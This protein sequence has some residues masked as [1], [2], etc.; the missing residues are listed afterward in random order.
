MEANDWRRVLDDVDSL[1]RSG[2]FTPLVNPAYLHHNGRPLVAVWGA[3][4]NDN[5][6]YGLDE[7]DRMVSGLKERG[8][9]VLLGV[10]TY[11]RTL[12][13]DTESDARLHDIISC[14]DVVMPWFVGRYNERS[15]DRHMPSVLAD[16][17]WCRERGVDYAPLAF[18]GFSWKNMKGQDAVTIP[19]NKGKFLKNQLNAYL[20]ANAQMIY[21]AMFDEIDEGTAIFKCARK[22]PISEFGTTFVESDAESD[23]YLKIV[24]DAAKKLKLSINQKKLNE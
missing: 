6:K 15:F 3:G 1:S 12:T 2:V 8:F 13:S 21:V 17:Q 14:C 23:H 10:P 7:I 5:R 24:G 20:K 16:M 22:V 19:R 9:S 18:P 11:W 4:F